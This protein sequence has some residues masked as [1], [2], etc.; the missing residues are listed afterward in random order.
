MLVTGNPRKDSSTMLDL[1]KPL[2]ED[3]RALEQA[4][5]ALEQAVDPGV[6]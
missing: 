3:S 2:A 1:R 6:Q 4:T 5:Q